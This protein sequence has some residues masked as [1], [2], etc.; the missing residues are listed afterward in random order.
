MESFQLSTD[1]T[2]TRTNAN[3]NSTDVA[4]GASVYSV[5]L[6]TG[7]GPGR[8]SPSR[9][10]TLG[11]RDQLF[12]INPRFTELPTQTTLDGNNMEKLK[13]L[14]TDC[15][16]SVSKRLEAS[17]SPDSKQK[18][19]S[20]LADIR[21]LDD[22]QKLLLYLQLP[23]GTPEQDIH[24][25][26]SPMMSS[27]RVD[28]V[29]ALNWVRSHIE[30]SPDTSLPKQ[31]VYEEYKTF[32]ENAYQRP[33]STADFGKIIKGVFPAVQARRLGTRGNS[34]YCYSGM[35]KKLELTSPSLPLLDAPVVNRGVD[36]L[37]TT[38]PGCPKSLLQGEDDHLQKAASQVICEWASGITN[39]TFNNSLQ[40]AQHLTNNNLVTKCSKSILIVQKHMGEV[41]R[42]DLT[43]EMRHRETNFHLKQTLQYRQEIRK[44]QAEENQQ[45]QH[46][47]PVVRKH[48]TT[49]E[50][51]SPQA[52]CTDKATQLEQRD[53]PALTESSAGNSLTSSES[54]E[55]STNPENNLS[56]SNA[57]G[58]GA[59][60]AS[61]ESPSKRRFAPIQPKTPVRDTSA[62]MVLINPSAK[63]VNGQP[64]QLVFMNGQKVIPVQ[65]ISKLTNPQQMN[66][67]LQPGQNVFQSSV[68]PVPAVGN[69]TP[70]N[71]VNSPVVGNAILGSPVLPANS[72]QSSIKSGQYVVVGNTI[73]QLPRG[74]QTVSNANSAIIP[75]Q[76]EPV[77]AN[78]VAVLA[79]P[80]PQSHVVVS[81]SS[82]TC[83]KTGLSSQGILFNTGTSSG[84][85]HN[86]LDRTAPPSA[87]TL[88]SPVNM[89]TQASQLASPANIIVRSAQ[90]Q[91]VATSDSS[92]L[93]TSVT[94]ATH[95]MKIP[96]VA[97]IGSDAFQ[98]DQIFSSAS[99]SDVEP[100]L[101]TPSHAAVIN[102]T[103]FTNKLEKVTS[104]GRISKTCSAIH[105][106]VGG[107][108]GSSKG[109]VL[110]SAGSKTVASL[111]KSAQ[112]S[113]SLASS[114]ALSKLSVP[115]VD[116]STNLVLAQVQNLSRKPDGSNLQHY[117]IQAA[118][119]E[120]VPLASESTSMAPGSTY[121]IIMNSQKLSS[122]PQGSTLTDIL[123][124]HG[125]IKKQANKSSL[126]LQTLTVEDANVLNQLATQPS[127]SLLTDKD[128]S[129]STMLMVSGMSAATMLPHKSKSH[130]TQLIQQLQQ[131]TLAVRTSQPQQTNVTLSLPSTKHIKV[132]HLAQ[133]PSSQPKILERLLA[134]D[135]QSYIN[136][137]QNEIRSARS[138]P[139]TPIAELRSPPPHMMMRAQS[140]AIPVQQGVDSVPPSP[141]DG[142]S[143]AFTPI[144]IIEL[145][146]GESPHKP[147]HKPKPTH[148]TVRSALS[149]ST[150]S[151]TQEGK[152]KGKRS[153]QSEFLTPNRKR[154]LSSN[155][156]RVA[157][158][159][160][161]AVQPQNQVYQSVTL[162][163]PSHVAKQQ[164]R[165]YMKTNQHEVTQGSNVDIGGSSQYCRGS[166]QNQQAMYIRRR[167]PSGPSCSSLNMQMS[168]DADTELLN[169]MNNVNPNNLQAMLNKKAL[170]N[171]S[172][173]VPLP[174]QPLNRFPKFQLPTQPEL[175]TSQNPVLSNQVHIIPVDLEDQVRQLQPSSGFTAKRNLTQDL[176]NLEVTEED[177]APEAL[178]NTEINAG[179]NLQPSQN[180]SETT[181]SSEQVEASVAADSNVNSQLTDFQ[182]IADQQNGNSAHET[183]L[184][185]QTFNDASNSTSSS[186][187]DGM[188]ME[189]FSD[190]MFQDIEDQ[191]FDLPQ[192]PWQMGTSGTSMSTLECGM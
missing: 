141:V 143:F 146:G 139:T 144:N 24:K 167:N 177:F 45:K 129:N 15:E 38:C 82:V 46:S 88:T 190:K 107:G 130:N 136:P 161:S 165:Y 153:Q 5:G 43:P 145:D 189:E 16:E 133:I 103:L 156:K 25:S 37:Y 83:Q 39:K 59:N 70:V 127:V 23:S 180:L 134:S 48:V 108:V 179:P 30:E 10:T 85:S 102:S 68:Q 185:N 126:T 87:P 137:L 14:D 21:K 9:T 75:N 122:V 6:R 150:S 1:L 61:K 91:S 64:M 128:Q 80:T 168:G 67:L 40:V 166:V 157:A 111:L 49:E 22:K 184:P 26:T 65:G 90:S 154:R 120:D 8:P 35:R 92:M 155:S 4:A 54:G 125:N 131:S 182:M 114:V 181:W 36:C 135:N 29:T 81:G 175:T 121:P 186:I 86:F 152:N 113:S 27:C 71:V 123:T 105:S 74:L 53:M 33:L 138:V 20:L 56:S 12:N 140:A 44:K 104:P 66:V 18:I 115:S 116:P 147:K 169:L 174:E 148:P 72:I 62:P 188:I 19:E 101:M 124:D 77:A 2:A 84:R 78:Q 94:Y 34:R 69:Q 118:T 132:Q 32:C 97:V 164:P 79:Q 42:S 159:S 173:S 73:R 93:K 98:G 106:D 109:G 3:P 176:L 172:Q 151:D 99:Q 149:A 89:T 63:N 117:V 183:L 142:N 96:P 17:L 50:N 58:E 13:K 112:A 171:R 191:N 160:P 162:P 95:P 52:T 192:T 28:Q 163:S 51:I 76:G 57:V 100:N 31:E 47:S 41:P 119:D 60:T 170:Q 158:A 187:S 55:S 11:D 178:L 110:H 7:T